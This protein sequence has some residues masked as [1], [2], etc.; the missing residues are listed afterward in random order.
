VAAPPPDIDLTPWAVAVAVA[1]SAVG[2]HLALY[3]SAY[4][5][6]LMGWFA[7]LLYGLFTRSPESKMPVWAYA[8]FTFLVTMIATVPVSQ[9]AAN[10][11]PFTYTAL[12]FPIAVAIPAVPDKWGAIGHWAFE[13]WQAARGLRP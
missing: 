1:G 11:V 13:R 4:A 2:P 6:I 5:L 9:F 8:L 7:G 12:L 10:Y 3:V